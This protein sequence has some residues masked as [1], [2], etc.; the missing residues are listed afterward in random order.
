[1]PRLSPD[2]RISSFSADRPWYRW[3][4]RQQQDAISNLTGI[5]FLPVSLVTHRIPLKD[6]AHAMKLLD[7]KGHTGV[8]RVAITP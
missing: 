3:M 8:V 2:G 4:N 1:M 5:A 7:Q 6:F